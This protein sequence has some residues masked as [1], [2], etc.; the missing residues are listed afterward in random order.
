M[1]IRH[2]WTIGLAFALLGSGSACGSSHQ[3][4]QQTTVTTMSQLSVVEVQLQHDLEYLGGC[5]VIRRDPKSHRLSA[6]P[7]KHR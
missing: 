4:V 2:G 5:E 7:C 1:R 6:E 3:R